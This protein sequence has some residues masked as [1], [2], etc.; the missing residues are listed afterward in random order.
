MASFRH[1]ART[2]KQLHQMEG[3]YIF[4]TVPPF[5]TTHLWIVREPLI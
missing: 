5:D 3:D 2:S 1:D 4:K